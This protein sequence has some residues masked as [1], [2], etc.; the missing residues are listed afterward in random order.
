MKKVFHCCVFLFSFVVNAQTF[1]KIYFFEDSIA[2]IPNVFPTDSGYYFLATIVNTTNNRYET[3]FGKLDLQGNVVEYARNEDSLT[4]QI[5]LAQRTELAQN[6]EG[7]FTFG[8]NFRMSPRMLTY[9][10]DLL[11]VLDTSYTDLYAIDSL[12]TYPYSSFHLA[13]NKKS[14][15]SIYTYY[16]E[17]NDDDAVVGN[18]GESGVLL[19]KHS[20]E[21][22]IIWKKRFAHP[23]NY[24]FKPPFSTMNLI[25][26]NDSSLLLICRENKTYHLIADKVNNFSRIH[27]FELDT[28]G[29]THYHFVHNPIQ[30]NY[31][32]YGALKTDSSVLV[33]SFRGEYVIHPDST[34][35]LWKFDPVI[36]ALNNDYEIEWIDTI[37]YAPIVIFSEF[38]CEELL[39][40]SDTTFV[41]VFSYYEV[42]R[43]LEAVPTVYY[44]LHPIELFNK[45]LSTG[46]TVWRRHF[47]FFPE[48]STRRYTHQM[49][50]V[51]LTPDGGYIMSGEVFS[52]DSSLA[53]VP[54]QYGYIAK[55]NCLGFFGAPQTEVDYQ[56]NGDL[57]VSF[58]N[59]SVQAGSYLWV[60]GDG[61]S[62]RVGEDSL[63]I[64]HTY[65]TKGIYEVTLIAYGCNNDNDTLVFE[66][67]VEKVSLPPIQVGDGSLLTLAPNPL[68]SG[69]TLTVYIGDIE[70]ECRLSISDNRGAILGQY[71]IP[72]GSTQ[73]FFPLKW[74]SGTY[75]LKLDN[76]TEILEVEKLVVK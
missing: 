14:Y 50:D 74:A 75:Y 16:D 73:Y 62:L 41:G 10:P 54:S 63:H 18:A 43:D 37:M 40:N 30:N 42:V 64:N 49:Y 19:S 9:S 58:Y 48:D 51:D 7:N 21:G 1:H 5:V 20:L 38:H 29:N 52:T 46:E 23:A 4:H 24:H 39:Q 3:L 60:F 68:K 59:K 65:P 67:E 35:Y 61:D 36:T 8:D 70:K 6:I 66:V 55:T 27:F 53:G 71:Q 34:S 76:E 13:Y 17:L 69:E 57:S 31:G 44:S 72:Q 26:A 15:Y 22:E 25:V 2:S 33:S 32:W 56:S 45:K 11:E 47:R 28:N 12:E